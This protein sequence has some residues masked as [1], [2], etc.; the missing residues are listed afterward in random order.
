MCIIY[1]HQK[2]IKWSERAGNDDDDDEVEY[3]RDNFFQYYFL[4]SI[5]S[6]TPCIHKYIRYFKT[7]SNNRISFLCT[8]N[9]K[10]FMC[11]LMIFVRKPINLY[12]R[13]WY[14][15]WVSFY[16]VESRAKQCKGVWS[17]SVLRKTSSR[18]IPESTNSIFPLMGRKRMWEMH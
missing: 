16:G 14:P 11:I 6:F 9:Y 12:R 4:F 5:S 8:L 3:I 17:S 18:R 1:V 10:A 15:F 2:S 7:Y 13:H